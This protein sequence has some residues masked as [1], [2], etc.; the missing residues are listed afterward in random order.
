MHYNALYVLPLN[1][2]LPPKEMQ[3]RIEIFYKSKLIVMSMLSQETIG[4]LKA[5]LK[6][7]MSIHTYQYRLKHG[8]SYLDNNDVEIGN[9][10][11]RDYL[12]LTAEPQFNWKVI[13]DLICSLFE[14]RGDLEGKYSPLLPFED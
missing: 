10:A 8:T 14:K 1:F 2:L 5:R 6:S 3:V 13:W 9:Y 4:D 7:E 11:W 12:F